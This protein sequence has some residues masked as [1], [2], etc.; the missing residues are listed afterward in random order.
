MRKCRRRLRIIRDLTTALVGSMFASGLLFG[1]M[2]AAALL[3]L[4]R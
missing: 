1:A 2:L 3:R 4:A